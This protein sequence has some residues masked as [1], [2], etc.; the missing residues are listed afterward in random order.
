MEMTIKGGMVFHLN[1]EHGNQLNIEY[2]INLDG[3]K[4]N[5]CKI[6]VNTFTPKI[7]NVP[8]KEIKSHSYYE[9][10]KPESVFTIKELNTEEVFT[11]IH[12][13][14]KA[15]KLPKLQPNK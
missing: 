6:Y 12:S 11:C 14:L 9:F 13:L 3:H 2:V 10:G 15:A 5:G 8:K 1:M 4:L 7:Y